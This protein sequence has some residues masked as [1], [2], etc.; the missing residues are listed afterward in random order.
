MVHT[1]M[2]GSKVVHTKMEKLSSDFGT[3]V[4]K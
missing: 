4:L 3:I 2:A 1:K